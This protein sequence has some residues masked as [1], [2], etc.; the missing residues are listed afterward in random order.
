M[1]NQAI[2][3]KAR[4]VCPFHQE[5]L[6]LSLKELDILFLLRQKTVVKRRSL[7]QKT[8]QP[9]MIPSIAANKMTAPS[10]DG[11]YHW[12]NIIEREEE[13]SMRKT[14]WIVFF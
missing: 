8:A 3:A 11:V 1:V 14:G 4:D 6:D 5:G 12:K 10:N 9:N 2:Y 7:A 13:R